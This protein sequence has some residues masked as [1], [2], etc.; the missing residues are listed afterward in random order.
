MEE[1]NG[2]EAHLASR[3]EHDGER[4]RA[5]WVLHEEILRVLAL[6]AHQSDVAT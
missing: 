3:G 6:M 5:A 1:R 2:D 4:K